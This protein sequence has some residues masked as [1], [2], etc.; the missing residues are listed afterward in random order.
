MAEGAVGAGTALDYM[1]VVGKGQKIGYDPWLHTAAAVE[2]LKASAK[3]AGAALVACKTN[4]IDAVWGDQPD[5][6]A[7][8]AVPH[9]LALAGESA[10]APTGTGDDGGTT[11]PEVGT[12]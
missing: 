8:K 4:P 3:K 10:E 5:A 9:G 1:E 2:G 7:A 11:A 6:P 12:T